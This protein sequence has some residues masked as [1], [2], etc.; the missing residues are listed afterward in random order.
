MTP[1]PVTL[2]GSTVIITNP[3]ATAMIVTTAITPRHETWSD[4]RPMGIWNRTAPTSGAATNAD[5]SAF[6]NPRDEA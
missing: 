4:S 3:S 2:L 5:T 1:S 6:V